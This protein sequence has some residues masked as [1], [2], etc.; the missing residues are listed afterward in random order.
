M[1]IVYD[2]M[3]KDDLVT[4]NKEIV[5]LLRVHNVL[6]VNTLGMLDN[7]DYFTIYL[8]D[9]VE[10]Y[11]KKEYLRDDV[12]KLIYSNYKIT[13]NNCLNNLNPNNKYSMNVSVSDNNVILDKKENNIKYTIFSDE[14]LLLLDLVRFLSKKDYVSIDVENYVLSVNGNKI[15]FDKRLLGTMLDI[16]NISLNSFNFST[17]KK[18]ITIMKDRG[19][20]IRYINNSFIYDFVEDEVNDKDYKE[21]IIYNT[22]TFSYERFSINSRGES[23]VMFVNNGNIRLVKKALN[24]MDLFRLEL[25]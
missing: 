25:R 3:Y 4:V 6:E 11:V 19:N 16:C 2:K 18:G 17:N 9:G 24:C 8:D 13:R 14:E 15:K 12:I 20:V 5:S 21:I 23:L 22:D 10:V 7:E 1:R